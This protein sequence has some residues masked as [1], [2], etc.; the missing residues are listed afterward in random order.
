MSDQWVLTEESLNMLLDWLDPSRER[1][2]RRYEEIRRRLVQF[3]VCR[4]CAEPEQLADQTIDRVARKVPQI[5]DDYSGDP[6]LYF[7]GVARKV[8]LEYMRKQ[9]A[10]PVAPPR[11][12]PDTEVAEEEY[13]CLERCMERLTP[14][15]RSLVL[16]YYQDE[17]QLKIDHRRELARQFGIGMNALRLRVFRIRAALQQCVLDCLKNGFARN[18]SRNNAIA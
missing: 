1:A 11:R 15:S 10:A 6:A 7:Y 9:R 8:H 14:D 2:G 16:K 5:A 18:E 12:E 17:R 4:G 3:F 13:G